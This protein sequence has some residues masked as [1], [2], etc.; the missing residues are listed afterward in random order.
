MMTPRDA[1]WCEVVAR[2]PD[3]EGEW[4]L[5]GHRSATPGQALRWLR[6][7]ARRLA[8]ALDPIPGRGP[9]PAGSLRQLGPGAPNPG[10]IFRE[11]AADLPFQRLQLAALANG[12]HISVNA[13]GPDRVSGRG[14]ANVYY[15]L[16]CRPIAL[17]FPTDRRAAAPPQHAHI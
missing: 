6:G 8:D 4:M 3:A 5:G 12:R 17:D 13:G 11:W 7:Q 9:F 15:S 10:R 1:Y 14:D 16:S 2:S